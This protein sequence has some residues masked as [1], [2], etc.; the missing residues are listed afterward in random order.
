[1][2]I[3]ILGVNNTRRKELENKVTKA[4]NKLSVVADIQVISVLDDILKY[5][6]TGI[7]AVLVDEVVVCQKCVPDDGKI[8]N[9]LEKTIEK[10]NSSTTKVALAI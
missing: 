6:V 1:M 2:K 7:P 10:K 8:L 5:D 9:W 4:V 3:K